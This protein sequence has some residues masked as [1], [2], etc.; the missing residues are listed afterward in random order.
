MSTSS[1]CGLWSILLEV[2]GENKTTNKK[3]RKELQQQ[4]FLNYKKSFGYFRKRIQV[5]TLAEWL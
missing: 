5:R 1:E 2:L 4:I 3:R